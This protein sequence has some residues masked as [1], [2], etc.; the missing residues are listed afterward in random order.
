LVSKKGEMAMTIAGVIVLMLAMGIFIYFFLF[1]FGPFAE[2]SVS[3]EACRDSVFLRAQSKL[4]GT[5][6]FEN[7]ACETHE[8]KIKNLNEE[9]IKSEISNEMYDCW[10]QF[11]KGERDFLDDWDW[12]TGNNYCFI[13][14]RIEFSDKIQ[15]ETPQ[16][17]GLMKYLA[18]EP[19]PFREEQSLFDYIY[20]D[21][22]VGQISETDNYS[23]TEPLYVVFF[24]DKRYEFES[25]TFETVTA[26]IGCIASA[27]AAFFTFGTT[28]TVAAY[29]CGI[30]GALILAHDD[31][32][33]KTGFVSGMYIGPANEVMGACNQ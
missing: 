31:L 17:S 1:E 5:T 26:G 13:C 21:T 23:T 3:R 2:D 29:T 33:R 32:H 10:Y 20:A 30:A 24:A 16:I 9:G 25:D 15:E 28:L 14:S 19:L 27:A 4:L 12:G 8:L 11:A 6:T 22:S 7:L 18:T